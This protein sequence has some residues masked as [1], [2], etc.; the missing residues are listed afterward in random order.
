MLLAV[1]LVM[2]GIAMRVIPHAPNFTPVAAIALFGG[3]YLHKKHSFFVPL[4]LM[5]ASDLIIGMHNTIAFTWGSFALIALIGYLMSTKVTVGRIAGMSTASS[6]LFYV[7]SNFGVWA[8]GWYPP[9]FAG[10]VSCYINA[11]PF[12][13]D[14]TAAT[15]VYSAVFFGAYELI[16]RR[17]RDTKFAPVFLKK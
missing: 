9:T 11:L 14:F 12:L 7:V 1:L 3:V 4:A 2:L 13:R 17:V 16:S 10:L 6:V 15:L 5:V 8:M